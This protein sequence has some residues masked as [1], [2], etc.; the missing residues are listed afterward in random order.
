M[1]YYARTKGTH[2]QAFLIYFHKQVS[3]V[4]ILALSNKNRKKNRLNQQK[5]LKKIKKNKKQK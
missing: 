2:T 3:F 5:M 4:C 1:L